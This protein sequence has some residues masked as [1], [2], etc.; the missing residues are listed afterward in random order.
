MLSLILCSILGLPIAYLIL[1]SIGWFAGG[2][3]TSNKRL[4][5]KIVVIT[6]ANTGNTVIR[7][8]IGLKYFFAQALDMKL[9]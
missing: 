5:G 1:W 4:D 3:C 9:P 6:G 2:K 8:Q 7:P